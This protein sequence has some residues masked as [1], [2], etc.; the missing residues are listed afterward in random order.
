MRSAVA[1][2]GGAATCGVGGPLAIWRTRRTLDVAQHDG[3]A[4]PS[5]H[6][7]LERLR[8]VGQTAHR[9]LVAEGPPLERVEQLLRG[10]AV[11]RHALAG[12]PPSV[13][14]TREAE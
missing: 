6:A 2:C 5:Q 9:K 3:E 8:N 11:E 7:Q 14:G 4:V 1:T 12:Y 10:N 13:L